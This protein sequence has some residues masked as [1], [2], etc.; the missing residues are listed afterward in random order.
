[1]PVYPEL[2]KKTQRGIRNSQKDKS[3]NQTDNHI[4]SL[5]YKT[6]RL[7]VQQSCCVE[8]ILLYRRSVQM[9]GGL[10]TAGSSTD[11][12]DWSIYSDNFVF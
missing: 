4:C 7:P 9:S 3:G 12:R 8:L 1:M 2:P 11:C 5:L 10:R 6:G